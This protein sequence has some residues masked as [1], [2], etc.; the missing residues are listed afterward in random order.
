M[1]K[2][3]KAW[4]ETRIGKIE[5]SANTRAI[6]GTIAALALCDAI[7]LQVQ[8]MHLVLKAL[9][10]NVIAILIILSM[11]FAYHYLRPRMRI[12]EMTHMTAIILAFS[13]TVS[14]LSY[15][16]TTLPRP[17]FDVEFVR[18]DRAL[19]LHWLAQYNWVMAHPYV[20][21]ALYMAY[22]TLIPQLLAVIFVLNFHGLCSRGWETM[23]LLVTSCVGCIIMSGIWPAE[24]AFGYYQ[25]E[26]NRAYVQVFMGLHNG[27][28]KTIGDQSIQGVI[29]FPSFHVALALV[30]TYAARGRKYLFPL[31]VELNIL[32]FLSTPSIGGHHFADLW[33]GVAL[34]LLS[35]WFV[36][37]V[38]SPRLHPDMAKV[39]EV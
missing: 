28:I 33:G 12:S 38:I 39:T 23:W 15:I 24:G 1:W 25:V 18:A 21:A 37:K 35:I 11:S 10:S 26:L 6:W 9:L 34:A 20:H 27:T 14:I 19:G 30:L 7:G 13:C 3:L 16:V 17:L 4:K 29:Q 22:A 2:K 31:L 36:R 32:L 8:G 5:P